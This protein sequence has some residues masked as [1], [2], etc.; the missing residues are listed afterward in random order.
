[1]TA[2]LYLSY[3][4]GLSKEGNL[5]ID[6]SV[7]E[8]REGVYLFVRNLPSNSKRKA[9]RLGLYL[10]FMFLI[11]QPLIPCAAAVVMALPPAI[12]RLSPIEQDKI[13]INEKYYP[14]KL[15]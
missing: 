1:M 8:N 11:S 6:K 15:V 10:V 14:Q 9:K 5:I 2:L 4:K 7:F 12:H 13:L 3:S